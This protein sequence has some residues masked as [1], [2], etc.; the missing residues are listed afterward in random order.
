MSHAINVCRLNV[1]IC[2][3][4]LYIIVWCIENFLRFKQILCALYATVP[5]HRLAE[6][7][8]WETCSLCTLLSLQWLQYAFPLWC[9]CVSNFFAYAAIFMLTVDFSCSYLRQHT[10]ETA[11]ATT[12][13]LYSSLKIMLNCEI[14]SQ[15]IFAC[16]FNA[17][18]CPYS[19]FL[20]RGPIEFIN[21]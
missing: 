14:F 9:C 5:S 6:R 7:E 21:A 11:I 15:A 10:F 2:A 18:T 20:S 13:S 16:Y 8:I 19:G 4:S 12:F 17:Y 3:S 1:C